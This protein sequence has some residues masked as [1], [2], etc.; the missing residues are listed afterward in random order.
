MTSQIILLGLSM[1]VVLFL[2]HISIWRLFTVKREML[3]L[4]ILFLALPSVVFST[5]LFF[6]MY[7]MSYVIAVG[8]LY[9]S[10][11][12]IYLQTYPAIKRNIPSFEILFLLSQHRQEGLKESDIVKNLVK[13]DNLFS[14]KL[15]ELKNDHLIIQRSDDL[16]L[17]IHGKILAHI[18]LLYRRIL[19]QKRGLG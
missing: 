11:A 3:V 6:K 19:G 15:D 2:V 17:T 13:K 8:L 14:Q 16:S 18:F 5:T 10:I 4:F 12:V 7:S 9:Y 1:F